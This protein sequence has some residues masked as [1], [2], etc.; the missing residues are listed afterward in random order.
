MDDHL[1]YGLQNYT[2]VKTVTF[3]IKDYKM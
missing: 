2:E 3:P 1:Q